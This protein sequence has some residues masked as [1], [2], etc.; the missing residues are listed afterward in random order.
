VLVAPNQMKDMKIVTQTVALQNV[1]DT[2]KATAKIAYD[3]QK[4]SHVYSPVS[5]KVS[6]VFVQL[7]DHVKKG[8]ALAS[9]DSPEI[10]TASADVSKAKAD[11]I[12]AEHD[13]K[14]QQELLEAHATS[15]RDY[16][17]AVDNYRKAK[18]ELERSQ[19]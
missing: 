14:R 5:G 12:A 11:V 16:E 9:I 8:D 7:G 2:V 15:Q 1:D 10:G 3:D 4:I 19:Q 13:I 18:A 17:I 6:K